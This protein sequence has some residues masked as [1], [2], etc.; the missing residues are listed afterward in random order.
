VR[1]RGLLL[2]LSGIGWNAGLDVSAQQAASPP[3]P[4]ANQTEIRVTARR[5]DPSA[6]KQEAIAYYR[7][8]CFESNRLRGHSTMPERDSNWAPLDDELRD[9]LKLSGPEGRAY[10]L[11]DEI[12]QHTLVLAS[13]QSTHD[14]LLE[15]RCTLVILG[16]TDTSLKDDMSDLFHSLPYR[17]SL[18][19]EFGMETTPGWKHWLWAAKPNRNSKNWNVFRRERDTTANWIIVLDPQLFYAESNYLLGDLKVKDGPGSKISVMSFV[20]ITGRDHQRG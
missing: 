12:R 7:R 20:F 14:G 18:E 15:S 8:Y 17:G 16:E 4:E 6:P 19:G 2:L 1:S 10:Q 3:K 13:N 5:F 11:V 9:K